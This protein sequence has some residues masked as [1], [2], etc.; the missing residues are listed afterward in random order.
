MHN[1][2]NHSQ[3]ALLFRSIIYSLGFA[4][5]YLQFYTDQ[6]ASLQPDGLAS[7]FYVLV[8]FVRYVFDKIV[9]KREEAL[10]VFVFHPGIFFIHS[11]LKCQLI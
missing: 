4:R 9:G 5:G 3:L 10:E 8:G 11:G 6:W 1:N 7:E 2:E